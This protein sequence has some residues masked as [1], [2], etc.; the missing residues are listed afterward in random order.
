VK[1]VSILY[2]AKIE[3]LEAIEYY[4]KKSHG[5]GI[6]LK[7][8]IK[9]SIE[10]IRRFPECCILRND[11]TRRFLLNRFPYLLIYFYHKK[12]IWIIALAHCKRKP[13]YWIARKTKSNIIP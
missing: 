7:N 8:E 6:D 5:L 11:E 9:S 4:E 13:E 1:K 12:H 2:E 10:I 3:I